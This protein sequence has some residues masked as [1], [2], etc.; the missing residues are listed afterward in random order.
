MTLRVINWNILYEID[1]P[2]DHDRYPRGAIS[3]AERQAQTA[4]LAFFCYNDKISA[5]VAGD[6]VASKDRQEVRQPIKIEGNIQLY[7][8]FRGGSNAEVRMK[9]IKEKIKL[10]AGQADVVCLQEVTEKMAAELQAMFAAT[11]HFFYSYLAGNNHGVSVLIDKKFKVIG[12]EEVTIRGVAGSRLVRVVDIQSPINQARV[13]V[14]SAHL[15]GDQGFDIPVHKEAEDLF[16]LLAG[17]IR[18]PCDTIIV[19]ADVN[20]QKR[21]KPSDSSPKIYYTKV[22]EDAGWR[23]QL[24]TSSPPGKLPVEPKPA[25]EALCVIMQNR[26]NPS[27]RIDIDPDGTEGLSDHAPIGTTI[28]L[29]RPAAAPIPKPVLAAPNLAPPAKPVPVASGSTSGG[30]FGFFSSLWRGLCRI[31]W[32]LFPSRKK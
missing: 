4:A 14:A 16:R 20:W 23:L 10:L 26:A 1:R 6:I 19:A 2:A 29:P 18:R 22:T 13:R 17:I 8:Y 30:F 5:P 12:S 31:F 7:T 28:V 27:E 3:G 11:H 9:Q 25:A 24:T 32:S 15:Y 21:A